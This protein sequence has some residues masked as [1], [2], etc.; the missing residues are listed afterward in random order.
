MY[1]LPL[2]PSP[3]TSPATPSCGGL[4]LTLPSPL[5]T[6]HCS[7]VGKEIITSGTSGEPL[8][9]YIFQGPIFYQKLKH[10]VMDK[11]HA[12]ARGPRAVLTRLVPLPR[13]Q[14]STQQ[15]AWS[16]PTWPCLQSASRHWP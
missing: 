14:Q 2:A 13:Q 11:M 1:T 3:D 6:M 8:L 7:Y 15:R 4:R 12:R 10:M 5:S 9:A 16:R